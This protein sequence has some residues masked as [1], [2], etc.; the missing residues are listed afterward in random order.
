LSSRSHSQVTDVALGQR[1]ATF[2]P[3]FSREHGPALLRIRDSADQGDPWQRDHPAVLGRSKSSKRRPRHRSVN[4]IIKGPAVVRCSARSAARAPVK[5][6]RV[7][8]M[9]ATTTSAVLRGR[10]QSRAYLRLR[11]PFRRK[12]DRVTNIVTCFYLFT[13]ERWSYARGW[14]G[15]RCSRPDQ[16]NWVHAF[17][18]SGSRWAGR[19]FPTPGATPVL[20]R[21]LDVDERL[22]GVVSVAPGLRDT[23]AAHG[24]GDVIE[25]AAVA[26]AERAFAGRREL[27]QTARDRLSPGRGE[28]VAYSPP[29]RA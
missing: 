28:R 2:A 14:L 26:L 11:V 17:A 4:L 8:S 5:F 29:R 16:P 23:P 27:T 15:W 22:M 24:S 3:S 21:E 18:K 20:D 13:S 6:S 7:N 10:R 25:S 12:A 9:R 1:D 19:F